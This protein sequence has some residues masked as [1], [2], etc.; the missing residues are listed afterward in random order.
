MGQ[1]L[2]ERQTRSKF[3]IAKGNFPAP[4]S[5]LADSGDVENSVALGPCS[6]SSRFL[7]AIEIEFRRGNRTNHR[8]WMRICESQHTDFVICFH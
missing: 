4:P 8:T 2:W 3:E 1:E 6:S 7:T 5:T